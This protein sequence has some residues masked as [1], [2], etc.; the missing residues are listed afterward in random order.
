MA[1]PRLCSIASLV[2]V[3]IDI[4][5]F[6]FAPFVIVLAQKKQVDINHTQEVIR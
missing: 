2:S 5:E 1:A 6:S 3:H 4:C